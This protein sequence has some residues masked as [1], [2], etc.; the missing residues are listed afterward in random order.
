[1]PFAEPVQQALQLVLAQH[2]EL[3]DTFWDLHPSGA[4]MNV[5]VNDIQVTPVLAAVHALIVFWPLHRVPPEKMASLPRGNISAPVRTNA[6]NKRSIASL[7]TLNAVW[8][9]WPTLFNFKVRHCTDG[10]SPRRRLGGA[11]LDHSIPVSLSQDAFKG[12]ILAACTRCAI[13]R[14]T[15]ICGAVGFGTTQRLSSYL[16]GPAP[17][18]STHER[19]GQ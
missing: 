6:D 9:R 19:T 8:D 16:L 5:P 7:P 18:G 12:L 1:V 15:T 4:H 13:R 3:T 14:T 10:P 17:F 2:N 11:F